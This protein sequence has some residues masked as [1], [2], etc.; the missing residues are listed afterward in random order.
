MAYAAVTPSVGISNRCCLPPGPRSHM[1]SD[2]NYSPHSLSELEQ[3]ALNFT[4][5]PM[6]RRRRLHSDGR[7]PTHRRHLPTAAT[8]ATARPPG[9]CCCAS[10]Q[11][12]A[13]TER[14]SGDGQAAA[15]H[16]L[17]RRRF[18]LPGCGASA[19]PPSL[20]LVA[21]FALPTRP[22]VLWD[23]RHGASGPL[24]G[25]RAARDRAGTRSRRQVVI[26][27]GISN[28]CRHL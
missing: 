25:P 5:W 8:P 18:S 15:E 3:V 16:Q 26:T 20:A 24:A 10:A 27:A 28:P 1:L 22:L 7:R 17:A 11:P 13:A 21:G 23:D 9:C 14:P 6:L 12:A 4:L 2:F 19:P